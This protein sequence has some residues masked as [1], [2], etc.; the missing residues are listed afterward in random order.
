[1]RLKA[2]LKAF[3]GRITERYCSPTKRF[4]PMPAKMVVVT[5]R[6]GF[7]R[8]LISGCIAFSMIPSC[9][10]IPPSARVIMIKETVP[11]MLEIPPRLRRASTALL[12][13]LATNPD[14]IK[15]AS[16]L[17]A[18]PGVSTKIM[19]IETKMF[20]NKI[21]MAGNLCHAQMNIKMIGKAAHQETEKF[22]VKTAEVLAML[23]TETPWLVK[24]RMAKR[25]NETKKA[26]IVVHIM[27]LMWAKRSEPATAEARLVESESGDIL[28]PNTAP[29]MMAP[30][31]R[32]GLTPNVD[33]IP[34][35]AN[36]TVETVVNPLPMAKPTREQT[37]KTDGTK[38]CALSK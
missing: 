16:L 14:S 9:I 25:I 6:P 32:A 20:K 10:R 28:S 22:L 35:R 15:V 7:F 24:P 29:E 11:I 1:M 12:P 8:R 4:T 38:N 13:V 34:K 33:P 17:M 37:K 21:G 30:A 31:V 5:K 19:T 3:P 2:L 26:G 36:P 27:F 23:L 18:N